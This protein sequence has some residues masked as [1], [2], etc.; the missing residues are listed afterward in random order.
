V[1]ANLVVTPH[2]QRVTAAFRAA[3]DARESAQQA[4]DA[5]S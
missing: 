5:G 4:L 2:D 1:R 3:D